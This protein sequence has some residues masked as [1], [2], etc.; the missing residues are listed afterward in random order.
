MSAGV[1]H[2]PPPSMGLPETETGSGMEL[3]SEDV[4]TDPRH[5]AG[6]PFHSTRAPRTA[7][8][9]EADLRARLSERFDLDL[10]PER[11][12]AVAVTRPFFGRT[13][14]WP[15]IVIPELRVAIEYDTVGRF[16]L[17]HV[18]PREDTD[19]RKD[20]M[21]RAVD[22]EVIRVRCGKLQPIGPHDIVAS[23]VTN[24]V[25]D[26]LVE[27]LRAI[28]GDLFVNAYLR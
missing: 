9:A 10:S 21:L 4:R 26:D 28:R 5:R 22:W 17:E 24:R 15:D 2:P 13:E 1:E 11:A 23:G 16:G 6:D 20:R 27:V 3:R 12:N 14:V 8:A 19:R 7:S 18:G 25:V